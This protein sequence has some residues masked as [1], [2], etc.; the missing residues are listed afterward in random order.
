M[1]LTFSSVVFPAHWR[2]S[3]MSGRTT[4]KSKIWNSLRPHF[5]RL[6]PPFPQNGYVTYQ[7]VNIGGIL[8]VLTVEKEA[9]GHWVSNPVEGLCPLQPKCCCTTAG[10]SSG[11]R[12]RES[13][14]VSKRQNW[15]A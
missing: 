1:A 14:Q 15:M 4:V 6:S 11:P 9:G 7:Q 12:L 13:E 10:L 2:S 8:L 5:L 3:S